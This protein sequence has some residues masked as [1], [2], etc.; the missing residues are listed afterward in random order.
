MEAMDLDGDA[1]VDLSVRWDLF[2]YSINRKSRVFVSGEEK[3]RCVLFNV[4]SGPVIGNFFSTRNFH[5]F[6]L[7]LKPFVKKGPE[8]CFSQNE[9]KNVRN[10]Y[11]S[12]TKFYNKKYINSI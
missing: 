4:Q 8:Q 10:V 11:M 3:S 5:V 7:Q 6:Y 1:V 12:S 9:T 2:F